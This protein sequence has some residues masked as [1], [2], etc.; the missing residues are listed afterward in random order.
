[1]GEGLGGWGAHHPACLNNAIPIWEF[2]KLLKF[3]DRG[4]LTRRPRGSGARTC[5]VRQIRRQVDVPP[6]RKLQIPEVDL[7]TAR[8]NHIARSNRKPAWKPTD[9]RRRPR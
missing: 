9:P 7:T 1:M 3:P 6:V 2:R 8:F 4:L 5:A